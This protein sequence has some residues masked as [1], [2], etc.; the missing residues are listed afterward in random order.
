M[1]EQFSEDAEA[2]RTALSNLPTE[3]DGKTCVLELKDAEFNWKQMEWIGFYFEI[4]CRRLLPKG[5]F[6]IPGERI[7]R[8][9]FDAKRSA[10]WDAKSHAVKT[11]S[12]EIV[13]NDKAAMDQSVKRHGWHGLI[14]ALL[15]C[16]YNDTDRA[17]QKWHSELKGGLSAYEIARRARTA[18]SRY[19][20]TRALLSEI[21]FIGIE[22][23][24]LDRLGTYSQG[25][26]SN[27]NPRAPKYTIDLEDLD[28]F[29]LLRWPEHGTLNPEA[30]PPTE[31]TADA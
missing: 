10:N 31:P 30:A 4:M 5:G 13:L 7:G 29:A 27:G 16:E 9:T 18:V 25:R 19:R 15:D 28:D 12:H 26:N 22:P 6:A 1:H 23:P 17:F 2:A 8:I 3:W 21:L 20:K 11:N 14:I 24:Q